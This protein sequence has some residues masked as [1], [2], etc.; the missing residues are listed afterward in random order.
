MKSNALKP[1]SISCTVDFDAP[2]KQNGFISVPTAQPSS[3]LGIVQIPL[4]VISNGSGPTVTLIASV[5]DCEFN[6]TLAVQQLARQIEIQDVS[7]RLILLPT[8]NPL[9]QQSGR[10][11][12]ANYEKSL[13]NSFPGNLQ[14]CVTEQIAAFF[15][16]NI[17]GISDAVIELR[18]GDATSSYA[19]SAAIYQ[20]PE[21][22]SLQETAEQTMIAFGAPNSVRLLPCLPGSLAFATQQANIPFIT[23]LLGGG[24][25]ASATLVNLALTGCNNALLQLGLLNT[26]LQLCSTRMLEVNNENCYLLA[27]TMGLLQPCKEVGEE[28]YRGN[29]IAYIVDPTTSGSPVQTIVA[30]RNGVLLARHYGGHI[31]AGE[32]VALLADEVQR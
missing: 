5:E 27:P 17:I 3:A 12:W 23:T 32:C 7:G 6:G 14:G 2:G 19:A 25:T 16:E 31:S 9:A 8:A 11:G 10:I 22:R 15:S 20:N 4:T 30:N 28:V 13:N 1:R 26:E 21:N 24:G 18:A 29:P